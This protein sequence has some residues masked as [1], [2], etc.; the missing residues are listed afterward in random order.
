MRKISL[1]SAIAVLA[2][3]VTVIAACSTAAISPTVETPAPAVKLVFATQ[4]AGSSAGS[5]LSIQPVVMVQ[6]ASGNIVPG[7]KVPLTLSITPDTG[8][9][10][11]VLFGGRVVNPV[12]GIATFKELSINLAGSGYKLTATSGTLIPA[13][14]TSF[15]ISAGLPAKLAFTIQP[16]GGVAGVPFSTQ[17]EVI[18]QDFYGNKVTAYEGSVSL[19]ITPGSG[20]STVISGTTTVRLV[21]GVARF[22]DLSINKAYPGYTLTARSDS[23][24]SGVSGSFTITSGAPSKLEFTVQPSEAKTGMP[25][26]TQPK[27]AIEDIYGNVVTSSRASVTL[28]IAPDTGAEGAILS[29]T[30]TLVA[31]G[32]L[33]GL[34]E[35]ADLSI[36]RAGS[37]YVLTATSSGLTSAKSQ[38]FDVVSP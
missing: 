2:T 3:L 19:G 12:K 8:A 32:G 6:D 26:E 14:S 30:K 29:G 13:T 7:Y 4:P 17:P 25:F 15:D 35:F 18:V 24:E 5:P 37:D 1:I 21:N 9:S 31:E 16:S 34:A 28:S 33:G 38:A 22:N 20:P 23:L 36:D 10:G 27:V 11:A